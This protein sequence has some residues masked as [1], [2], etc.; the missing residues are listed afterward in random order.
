MTTRLPRRLKKILAKKDA[1]YW[2]VQKEITAAYEKRVARER[3]APV[4]CVKCGGYWV[5]FLPCGFL[6]STGGGQ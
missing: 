4:A 2:A 5:H 6:P 1:S 3:N